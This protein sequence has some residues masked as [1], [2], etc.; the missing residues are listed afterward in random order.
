MCAFYQQ[1]FTFLVS[2]QKLCVYFTF[3]KK[4]KIEKAIKFG[5]SL[6]KTTFPVAIFIKV[7]SKFTNFC[8]TKK[9]GDKNKDVIEFEDSIPIQST[10]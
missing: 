9:N 6:R 3:F 10:S 7:Y 2:S 8:E 1:F 5:S 4:T